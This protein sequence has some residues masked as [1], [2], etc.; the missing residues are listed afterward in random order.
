MAPQ[1]LLDQYDAVVLCCG[2]SQP[3][4][5]DVP[6]RDAQGVLFAVDFL[7]AVTKSLL[8]SQLTDGARTLVEGKNVVIVGSGDTCNDCIGTSIRLG[9]R[10][11][12][13]LDRNQPLPEHRSAENPW[14]QWPQM[15][16]R[17]RP[18]GRRW[19]S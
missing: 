4:D 13:A 17:D 11:V 1:E 16:I 18:C 19:R 2:A 3:R 10:S 8:D 6:G 14:P 12:L 15:C 9:C 7:T 5:L